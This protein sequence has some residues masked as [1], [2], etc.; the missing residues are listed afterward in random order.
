MSFPLLIP[1]VCGLQLLVHPWYKQLPNFTFL[2]KPFLGFFFILSLIHRRIFGGW[3]AY[4]FYTSSLNI[5]LPKYTI[6]ILKKP[7][8][9]EDCL[10]C[11]PASAHH[12]LPCLDLAVVSCIGPSQ[13]GVMNSHYMKWMEAVNPQLLME[14]GADYKKKF[15]S[16][17]F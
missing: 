7:W 9:P 12:V 3:G 17:L 2:S 14:M 16:H 8:C 10:F 1:C 11:W 15:G 4:L 6:R 5:P 13:V